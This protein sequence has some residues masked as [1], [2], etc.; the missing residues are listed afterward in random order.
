M[1]ITTGRAPHA[2]IPRCLICAS[3]DVEFWT[4]AQDGEYMTSAD[5]FNLYRC[6]QCDVLFIDPV[7]TDRLSEIYP[8]NYYSFVA[9]KKS[10]VNDVKK[11]LDGRMFRGIMNT[12]P[13]KEL[14][15]LDVGGGSG[16]ELSIVRNADPRV[17]FSQV[18]DFDPAAAELAKENGHEYFCGRIEEFNT[19]RKF[20]FILMLNL[21]EHVENPV[22]ILRKAASMLSPGGR[23]LIKTPN[24]D[25]LDAR[26]F[27]HANWGGY[28]C[29]RHWV[30][31]RE[32][33]FG[34]VAA[35]AK[36]RNI[37]FSYTQGAPFWTA[38][39][40]FWLHQRNMVS[41]TRERPVMYHPLFSPLAALFAAFDLLRKPLARTSQ[42]FI[43]LGH[44]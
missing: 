11:W 22:E 40:L 26:L 31:F 41:I 16:W 3:E 12:I 9:Q 23:I 32:E 33:S 5:S 13:G 43:V 29:P 6:R 21:I 36:L 38:S 34:R 7:P 30:I 20:D 1:A 14:S 15:V 24:F 44:A 19:S 37:R 10:L 35:H 27:R 28:H 18:V 25:S 8:Q 42:M 4:K 39:T 2:D 17:A